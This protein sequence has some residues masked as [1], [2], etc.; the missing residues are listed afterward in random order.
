MRLIA[1]VEGMSSL[2]AWISDPDLFYLSFTHLFK[3]KKVT[4]M[5]G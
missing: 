3:M 2:T 5:E 4:P 1:P